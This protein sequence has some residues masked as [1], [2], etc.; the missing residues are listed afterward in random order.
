MQMPS[1]EANIA[2]SSFIGSCTIFLFT[3]FLTFSQQISSLFINIIIIA[4]TSFINFS[5]LKCIYRNYDFEIAIRASFLGSVFAIGLYIKLNTPSNI[6]IFGIY[7][8]IMAIFHYTE[9]LALALIDPKLV[10]PK[11]FVI[12]HSP[13]YTFAALFS[14]VEF[15]TETYFWPNLKQYRIISLLGCIICIG[16]EMLRKT[17]MFNAG[18]N[19][20]HLVQY[21]KAK[22]HV[23]V[24]TGVYS[25]FR[26]PSYVGWFYW[27]IG[28]QIVLLN[29]ISI[30]GYAI[31]SWIFF[32]QRIFI[33]EL[34]LLNFF[35][36]QYC[37]YQNSVSTGIPF[38]KG[39]LI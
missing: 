16:G 9:F 39:Y 24:T 36:Q 4:I 2:L 15:F 37:D 33:E 1:S 35:G 29:P 25:W 3:S 34:T 28:T 20:N 31:A 22:D 6:E 38:I 12:N 27:S 18:T 8:C 11:S 26:H 10:S 14:W 30:V 19:F 21:K 7:M 17:A 5:A 32:K 23:L 13:E